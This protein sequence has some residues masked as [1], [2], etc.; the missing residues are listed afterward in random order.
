MQNLY[1]LFDGPIEANLK[2]LKT[3]LF[4]QIMKDIRE[5]E[6]SRLDFAGKHRLTHTVVNSIYDG[7]LSSLT[8][9]ELYTILFRDGYAADITMDA[10]IVVNIDKPTE[11]VTA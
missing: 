7:D 4:V 6:I 11:E 1:K 2:Y 3:S 5:Q 8:L 9:E 10:G